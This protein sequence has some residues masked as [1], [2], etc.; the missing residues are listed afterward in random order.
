[1][2]ITAHH[3]RLKRYAATTLKWR[4]NNFACPKISVLI[5]GKNLGNGKAIKFTCSF[6]DAQLSASFSRKFSSPFVAAAILEMV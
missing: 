3:E 5:S 4:S 6:V 1:M 2:N